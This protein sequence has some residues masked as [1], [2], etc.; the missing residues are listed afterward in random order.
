MHVI[1][2]LIFYFFFFIFIPSAILYV[3]FVVYKIHYDN[4]SQVS[5]VKCQQARNSQ[6]QARAHQYTRDRWE[7]ALKRLQ[8]IT[9]DL[10]RS[11]LIRKTTTQELCITANQWLQ[12]T[13]VTIGEL[14]T[15][16]NTHTRTEIRYGAS[17]GSSWA[18]LTNRGLQSY[19]RTPKDGS[20][21]I[22]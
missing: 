21:N 14:A 17:V 6:S 8:K 2:I 20:I 4:R 15:T 13:E 11:Q 7:S 1:Y 18:F 9:T 22:D 10:S 19:R 12:L 3:F 16:T 5:S